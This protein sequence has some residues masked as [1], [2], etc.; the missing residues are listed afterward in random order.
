MRREQKKDQSESSSVVMAAKARSSKMQTSEVA[1]QAARTVA[2]ARAE[3]KIPEIHIVRLSLTT[4]SEEY[5]RA[6]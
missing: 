6:P 5:L 3:R 1:E 2:E 4:C